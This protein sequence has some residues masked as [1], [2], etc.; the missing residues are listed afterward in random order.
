MP[1]QN[2]TVTIDPFDDDEVI[3]VDEAAACRLENPE[4]CEV[5]E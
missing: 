3:V 1:E 5:C 2:E 4:T